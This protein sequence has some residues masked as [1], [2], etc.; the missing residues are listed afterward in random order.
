MSRRVGPGSVSVGLREGVDRQI[1]I[2]MD[3]SVQVEHV[4][5]ETDVL[6]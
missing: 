5:F 2:C 3:R 4:C 1:L 6:R